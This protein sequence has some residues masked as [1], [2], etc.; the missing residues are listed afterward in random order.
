MRG[1]ARPPPIV[2]VVEAT[3]DH[4]TVRR[5]MKKLQDCFSYRGEDFCCE[6]KRKYI[7]RFTSRARRRVDRAVE[8]A[9][10]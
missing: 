10:K 7:K 9:A 1:G 3:M 4:V 6:P 2:P 5:T 8:R